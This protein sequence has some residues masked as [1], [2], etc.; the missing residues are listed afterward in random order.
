M[1]TS[2][3]DLRAEAST[4]RLELHP[5]INLQSFLAEDKYELRRERDG[6]VQFAGDAGECAAFLSA[7]K[8][9]A[10]L[11]RRLRSM[12]DDFRQTLKDLEASKQEATLLREA[13]RN[14]KATCESLELSAMLAKKNQ[15]PVELL[16]QATVISKFDPSCDSVCVQCGDR[17]Q[18][19]PEPSALCSPCAQS[20]VL[21]VARALVKAA[22]S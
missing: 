22:A 20:F 9:L 12:P 14:A 8:P 19:D 15:I 21:T 6:V 5:Q 10:G 7:W 4:L 2:I 13:L 17:N 1:S 16:Q 18:T 3:E 11:L